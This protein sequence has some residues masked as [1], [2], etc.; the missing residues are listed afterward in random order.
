MA[1]GRYVF[2]PHVLHG[3]VRAHLDVPFPERIDRVVDAVAE[4]YPGRIVRDEPWIL[5]NAG[6]AMGV[7]KILH[8]SPWEYLIV[9]GSP[10]GTEGHTGR[11][12]ADDYFMVLEGEQWA[13]VPGERTRRVYRPGDLHHLP[14]GMAGG[15]RFP[16][17]CWALEY[18]RGSILSMLPFGLADGLSSTLDLPS[19]AATARTFVR[20]SIRAVGQRLLRRPAKEPAAQERAP[21]AG[22]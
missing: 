14:R 6:G 1:S 2:D 19:L 9:F 16:D 15:Y 8:A 22:R 5:N 13:Y 7:M 18:A 10:I 11:F 3:I 17:A 4:R 20:L 12:R 21:H